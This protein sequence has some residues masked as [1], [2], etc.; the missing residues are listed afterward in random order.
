[1]R[2][3]VTGSAGL[4]GAEVLR[5]LGM[6]GIPCLGVD[7]PDF[8]PTDSEAVRRCVESFAPDVIIHCSG[9]PDADKTGFLPEK[10]AYING[11]GAL[12]VARAAAGAGAKMLCLSSPQVFSGTGE[13]PFA[14]SDPYG[15]KTVYGMSKVQAE[16]AV[17]SLLTRYFIVRSDW[18]YGSGKKDFIRPFLRAAQEKKELRVACDQVGSPTW[19]RDLAR[20]MCDLIET[21]RYGIWHARNE[22]FFSRAEFAEMIIKKSGISCRIIPVPASE[23]PG[24]VIRPLNLRLTA[25]LPSGIGPMPSVENALDR[26]LADL[27]H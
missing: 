26:Y 10:C 1:M 14:V 20:V 6:R 15:P 19:A 8:D 2:V 21:D 9:Y 16:D 7:S 22:G 11:F 27:A 25:D 4:P 23:L 13:A 24:S 17:R 18:I 3:L 12:T 5:L